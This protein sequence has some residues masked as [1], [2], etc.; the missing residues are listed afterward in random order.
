MI[1]ILKL[2]KGSLKLFIQ[3]ILYWRV[4]WIRCI[5]YYLRNAD[6]MQNLSMGL[7]FLLFIYFEIVSVGLY[8]EIIGGFSFE[9]NLNT[10]VLRKVV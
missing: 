5:G 6:L 3:L 9:R 4:A 7:Y 10:K 1:G 8:M 2:V